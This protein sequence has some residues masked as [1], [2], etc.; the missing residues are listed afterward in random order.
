MAHLLSG[1]SYYWGSRVSAIASESAARFARDG[2]VSTVM[3][4]DDITVDTPHG[5]GDCTLTSLLEISTSKR[6]RILSGTHL[7][8][9]EFKLTPELICASTFQIEKLMYLVE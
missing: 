9:K 5:F 6:A 1:T 3:C 4:L 8:G 7:D 2:T